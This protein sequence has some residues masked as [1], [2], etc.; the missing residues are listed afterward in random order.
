MAA[1]VELQGHVFALDG[2]HAALM[3]D[4]P[5]SL[6]HTDPAALRDQFREQGY[7]LVRELLPRPLVAA[8]EA[9]IRALVAAGPQEGLGRGMLPR[10]HADT[11]MNSATFRRVSHGPEL[12]GLFDALFDE[13]SVTLD[14]KHFRAVGPGN[15]TPFHMDRTYMGRGSRRLTTAWVP[16]GTISISARA[17]WPWLRA[18]PASPG[19]SACA[20][21][22][23]SRRST[24][25]CPPTHTSA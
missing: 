22:T 24:G 12:F 23:A 16:H 21:R 17:A 18:A 4:T 14:Y 19:S 10:Q 11:I 9:E 5:A 20:K 15:G 1:A 2:V 3:A 6:A 8:V 7:L 13:P 25:C